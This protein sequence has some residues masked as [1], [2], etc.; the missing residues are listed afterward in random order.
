MDDHTHEEKTGAGAPGMGGYDLPGT[1]STEKGREGDVNYDEGTNARGQDQDAINRIRSRTFNPE[2]RELAERVMGRD[3]ESAGRAS[4]P[5]GI[6]EMSEDELLLGMHRLLYMTGSVIDE[7]GINTSFRPFDVKEDFIRDGSRD[8]LVRQL[9]A[10]MENLAFPLF[11]IL[12][13]SVPHRGYVPVIHTL[14]RQTSENIVI[15]I[16]SGLFKKIYS[17]TQ[18]VILEGETIQDEPLLGKIFLSGDKR[19]ARIYF[20]MVEHC[21][22]G[23]AAELEVPG[24]TCTPSI[25]PS[26]ICMIFTGEQDQDARRITDLLAKRLPLPLYLLDDNQSRGIVSKSFRGLSYPFHLLDYFFNVFLLRKENV[27]LSA[28]LSGRGGARKAFLMKYLISKLNRMLGPESAVIHML[29]NRLIILTRPECVGYIREILDAHD[30]MF[31]E[32]LSLIE[33]HAADFED[34]NSIIQEIILNN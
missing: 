10:G 6:K 29:K 17:S 33:F 30:S 24:L 16:R 19:A 21:T 26:S 27:G 34:S 20:A 7:R 22:G 14:D 12:S 1:S 31:D 28:R 8:V 15:S 23:L 9:I 32:K 11:A 2:L 3:H 13:Y 5:G 25:L 4:R 18:G